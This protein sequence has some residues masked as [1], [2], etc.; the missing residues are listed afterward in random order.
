VDINQAFA[1]KTMRD[2]PHSNKILDELLDA[3]EPITAAARSWHD[4]HCGS[5]SI[6]CA[7]ASVEEKLK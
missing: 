6:S 7:S 1:L 4:F 3:L 5:D 2:N